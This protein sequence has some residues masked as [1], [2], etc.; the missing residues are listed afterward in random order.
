MA[1]NSS[2]HGDGFMKSARL[3]AG[4]NPPRWLVKHL[5]RW[6]YSI[7][8]NGSVHSIQPG[9]A[10][11]K[12]RL[13]KLVASADLMQRE[14]QDTTIIEFLQIE[15]LGTVENLTNVIVALQ[16]IRRR[17]NFALSSSALSTKSGK[18]KAGRSRALPPKAS[19]PRAGCAA[20]ILE[21]WAHFHDG[22]FPA[23]SNPKLAAVADEYWRACGGVVEGW[24]NDPLKAW[25]PYF[26]EALKPS[27]TEIRKE[28]RRHILLSAQ[29]DRRK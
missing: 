17:A 10:E 22:T 24:G 8:L 7:M 20:V 15:D 12:A 28:L 5:Q 23:A 3:I 29:N 19:S 11:V 21:A 6:S 26:K 25:R 2:N 1:S 27:L 4:E 16:D 14:L 18:T 13:G 9:R